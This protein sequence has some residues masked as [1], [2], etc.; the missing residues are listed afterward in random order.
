ML[1]LEEVS[2][3][4]NW[5]GQGASLTTAACAWRLH[6]PPLGSHFTHCRP[7][8]LSSVMVMQCIVSIV[9]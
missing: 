8:P 9:T 3:C 5:M 6:P 7:P 2:L 4:M 1:M